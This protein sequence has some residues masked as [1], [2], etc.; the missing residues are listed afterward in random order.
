MNPRAW[1]ALRA[2]PRMLLAVLLGLGVGLVLPTGMGLASRSLVGWNAGVWF[3]LALMAWMMARA[4]HGHLHRVARA[5]QD[6]A[7]AMLAIVV[8]AAVTSIVALVAELARYKVAGLGQAA[9]HLALAAATVV[10]G[11]LLMPVAFTL[12]YASHYH[13]SGSQPDG[14]LRFPD[15]APAFRPQYADF[16]YFAFTIAVALQTSDVAV[17]NRPMRRLVLLQ[18]VVSF[19]FNTA[20]LSLAIG[21]AASLF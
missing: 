5:H 9:P 21:I 6:G 1:A 8:A 16:L 15:D 20:I 3:Y 12:S 13:R 17:T 2:R 7:V 11:W 19:V 10:G 18:S 4:D 14:G